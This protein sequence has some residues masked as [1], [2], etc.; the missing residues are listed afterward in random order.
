M[1]AYLY[2]I[3]FFFQLTWVRLNNLSCSLIKTFNCIVAFFLL[4]FKLIF[5][6]FYISWV[7]FC[8]II[9]A[10][11]KL[12]V[13]ITFQAS[14]TLT[15]QS[16]FYFQ[17]FLIKFDFVSKSTGIVGRTFKSLMIDSSVSLVYNFVINLFIISRMNVTYNISTLGGKKHLVI[18]NY[19]C[20]VISEVQLFKYVDWPC[21]SLIFIFPID[22]YINKLFTYH[23]Y[24]IFFFVCSDTAYFLAS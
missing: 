17:N 6:S 4:N 11:Y 19:I 7:T 9:K 21:V 13:S 20:W 8:L 1:F 12:T 23:V 22:L 14:L 10:F 15:C 24:Y 16:K 3:F 18:Y 2:I 5:V